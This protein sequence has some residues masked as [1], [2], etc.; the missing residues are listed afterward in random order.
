M[1]IGIGK[2]VVEDQGQG[3]VI[4]T[5]Q[6]FGHGQSQRPCE[7]FAHA[8]T[9]SRKL[10]GLAV[11]QQLQLLEAMFGIEGQ[12]GLLRSCRQEGPEVGVEG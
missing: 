8:S 6:D 9:E 4:G 7:L 5:H 1:P 12:Q 3:A 11:L 10:I 2:G